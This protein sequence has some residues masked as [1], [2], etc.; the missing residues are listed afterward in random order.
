MFLGGRVLNNILLSRPQRRKLLSHLF[1]TEEFAFLI[2][3][4]ISANQSFPSQDSEDKQCQV[5]ISARSC[6]TPSIHTVAQQ[7]DSPAL[8][9]YLWLGSAMPS[10]FTL[11][12]S[13][14]LYV[15]EVKIIPPRP[16]VVFRMA[17]QWHPGT[18]LFLPVLENYSI[19][20]LIKTFDVFLFISL[21]D[22]RDFF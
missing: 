7:L 11:L 12:A 6:P 14:C 22:I 4:L 15:N 5:C 9:I 21:Y 19:V 18:Y 3:V 16:K 10:H 20:G 8:H 17:F 1:H 13:A 2:T